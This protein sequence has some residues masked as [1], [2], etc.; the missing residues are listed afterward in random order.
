M[1]KWDRTPIIGYRMNSKENNLMSWVGR[2]WKGGK[3][4]MG[5]RKGGKKEKALT[6]F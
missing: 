6:T 4:G 1:Q 3:K 2:G 5:K